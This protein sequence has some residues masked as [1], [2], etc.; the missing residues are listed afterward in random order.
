M[1]GALVG[2]R[3]SGRAGPS[4]VGGRVRTGSSG[5]KRPGGGSARAFCSPSGECPA[6]AARLPSSAPYVARAAFVPF[7]VRASAC[8]YV[9]CAA[10]MWQSRSPGSGSRPRLRL[11]PFCRPGAT[12]GGGLECG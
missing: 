4:G 7:P 12:H 9:A 5:R 3:A 1:E 2:G 10:A 11:T 8:V 6:V